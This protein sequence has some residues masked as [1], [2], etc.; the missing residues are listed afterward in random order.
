MRPERPEVLAPAGDLTAIRAALAAGADAVYFGLAD[1]FNARARAT[2]VTRAELP[3]VMAEI[4][5]G[6]AR[7]Y[8]TLNT[9]LFETELQPMEDL[10]RDVAAAG[11]DALIV[12]DPAVALLAQAICPDL[13]LHASTQMTISSAEGVRFARALGV[14]RVVLPRELS[15]KEIKRLRAEADD[16]ELE[17][18]VHGALCVS[19][20]GQCLTSEAWGGRSANRGQCAQS[21]RMPYDLYVDGEHR[22]LGDVRYLLSPRDLAAFRA[23]PALAE[24]GV[25]TLKIEG[26]YKGPAYVVAAVEAYRRWTAAAARPGGPTEADEAR[27]ADDLRDLGVIYSRGFS[28]GFLGGAD[29]QHLV[30]GRY[31]KHRGVCLGVVLQVLDGRRVRVSAGA[32]RPRT[33]G[34]AL[35]EARGEA[36]VGSRS[37]PLLL[38]GGSPTD[39]TG[40]AGTPIEPRPGLG[41]VFDAGHPEDAAEPGGPIFAVDAEPGA[42]VLT[43]GQPGP[44]LGRVR[45]GDFVWI[46]GDP[47][48]ER[49]AR[50]LLEAPVTGRLPLHLRVFGAEGQ[51]LAVEARLGARRAHAQSAGP[52]TPARDGGLDAALLADK[53]GAFGGTAYHLADLDAAGLAPGLHLPVSALKALRRALVAAL[54]APTA[55]RIVDARPARPRLPAAAAPTRPLWTPDA[56]LL[57]PVCRTDEHVTAVLAAGLPV[58]ELDWMERAGLERA[59][60]R[61]RA[62]GLRVHIATPRVQKPGEEGFD[63]RIA[64]L[65]PEG[66]LVRHFG[67]LV[68]FDEHPD[69][70]RPELHGDFSLNVTNSLT[71]GRL[72]ALGLDTLTA[73]HDLDAAQLFALL[74][75]VPR[76]RLAVTVHHHIP[77]FH[78]EHCVYAHLLSDGRDIRSCGQPCQDHLIELADHQG[79]RHPV[80]VDPACRNTVYNAQAQ[81]A[82][83]LVPRLLD[84]GVRRFRVEFVREDTGE[85][86]RILA[87]YQALLRGDLAPRDLLE[88]LRVQARFGVTAGTMRTLRPA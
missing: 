15:V 18:F 2:G 36:P 37:E 46:T 61:A 45:P 8:L 68:H 28:D 5:R 47:A 23:V 51:P 6:G 62:A 16:M 83:S 34:L 33:G 60:E 19:W 22:P 27:V 76:G 88:R 20:S 44:D 1:G 63:R 77:T 78:T 11:V 86:L 43:F 74:P 49:R 54:D 58:I 21:C 32:D 24:L 4:H 79:L 26:R 80:V 40:A 41:V 66:V 69:E 13:E 72:L 9:L 31:P 75:E 82:A 65:E 12:Q 14:T 64:R 67:A 71:A 53:L 3:A 38:L 7:A 10:L 48:L 30:E 57:L 29:H 73:A 81:S 84:A 52:L 59:V 42:Y 56:P 50:K 39:G 55:P 25:H 70:R 35:G 87:G 85:A 17:V